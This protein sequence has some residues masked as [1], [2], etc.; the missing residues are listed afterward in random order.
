MIKNCIVGSGFSAAITYLLLKQ[1][2]DVF[3]VI[4]EKKLK[5][6]GLKK[7]DNLVCN[8]LFSKKIYSM[9]TINYHLKKGIFHDRN[10]LGGNTNIWGGHIDLKKISKKLIKYLEEKGLFFKKLSYQDTGTYCNLKSIVQIQD[11]NQNIFRSQSVFHKLNDF[12]LHSFLI[13]R[14]EIFLNLVN[15]QTLKIK[16]VKVKK[17]FLCIGTIQLIE[18]LIRSNYLKN[19]DIIELTEFDHEFKIRFK[20]NLSIKNGNTIIKY[21]LSRALGHF[22]GIQSFKAYLKLFNFIPVYVEQIFYNK[23]KNYNLFYKN[24][25]LKE[26]DNKNIKKFGDSIHYCNMKINGVTIN[27]FFSKI[28]KNLLGF[29]M[30]FVDQKTPGPISNDI[31]LSIKNKLK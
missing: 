17:L 29:G 2:S 3:T 27:K 8:K 9:G 20:K 19:N 5:K 6:I 31:I 25:S 16:K 4:S 23:K 18:L 13:K 30:S 24:H 21:K 11:K 15:F 26:I 7:R 22:L 12:F 28:H 10:T 14:K 1:K